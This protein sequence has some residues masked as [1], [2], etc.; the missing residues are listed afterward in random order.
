MCNSNI[1][2]IPRWIVKNQIKY[3]YSKNKFKKT[4]FLKN[5]NDKFSSKICY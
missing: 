5:I 2:I 4:D 3:K 1:K